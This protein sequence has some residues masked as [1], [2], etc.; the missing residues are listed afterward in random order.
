MNEGVSTVVTALIVT[1]VIILIFAFLLNMKAR[2]EIRFYGGELDFKVKYLCFTVFP[3]RKKEKQPKKSKK[4]KKRREKRMS[5]RRGKNAEAGKKTDTETETE[6]FTIKNAAVD[7]TE[8]NGDGGTTDAE[9]EESIGIS[10]KDS[11]KKEKLTDKL[12]KLTD[13]IEKAKIIWG[14][15][16]KWLAHI[17][18]HIYFRDLVIDFTVSGEDAYKAAMNYGSV[19]AV[20]YGG[21]S[22]L[23]A[24]FDTKIKTVDIACDFNGKRSVFD[25]E[26]KITLSPGTALKAVFGILFG[27]LKNLKSLKNKASAEEDG[28]LETHTA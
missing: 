23:S 5:E 14:F 19:S 20:T 16:K 4:P 2:A 27:V 13:M 3:L 24:L 22:A 21:I 12:E 17:F 15:S 7:E 26:V 1:S 28:M 6:S 11:N 9:N 18:K 10:G 8:S 25:G